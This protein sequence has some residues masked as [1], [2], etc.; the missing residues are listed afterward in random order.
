MLEDLAELC[1]QIVDAQRK[2]AKRSHDVG[3]CLLN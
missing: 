3:V 1:D 2:L